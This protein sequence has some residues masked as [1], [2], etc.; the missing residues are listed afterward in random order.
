MDH[1][2]LPI[3]RTERRIWYVVTK[4]KE[5]AEELLDVHSHLTTERRFVRMPATTGQEAGEGHEK[6]S[7]T[8]LNGPS[9]PFGAILHEDYD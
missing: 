3:S 5:L 9:D 1:P 2:S 7:L 4:M 6:E 8:A